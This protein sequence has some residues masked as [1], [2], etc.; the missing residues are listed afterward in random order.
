MGQSKDDATPD[1]EAHPYRLVEKKR[2]PVCA[3]RFAERA[4][5]QTCSA[6]GH[7]L[8]S[9]ETFTRSYIDRV[10]S[11]VPQVVVI[12][13]LLSLIPVIG[14]IP[15]VIYYRV[16]LVAPFRRY[17]PMGRRFLLKWLLRIFFFVLIAFQWVP[18]AGGLV[19]PLMAI[20]SFT[21]YRSSFRDLAAGS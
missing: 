1:P 18:L 17:M 12:C 4:V 15:G 8:M 20:V 11:R 19:V 10:S 5:H 2:C 16:A 14:L 3:T 13:A 9:E 21:T 6:C 7:E